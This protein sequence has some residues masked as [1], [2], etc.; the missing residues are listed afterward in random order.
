MKPNHFFEQ[1]YGQNFYLFIDWPEKKFIKY[2]EKNFGINES[3]DNLYDG[4][5]ML[6][7]NEEDR[8]EIIVVWTNAKLRATRRI[9]VIAHECLHAIGLMYAHVGV[10]YDPE[11][12]EPFTYMQGVLIEECLK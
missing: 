12:D 1:C 2:M 4:K 8:V 5:T 6:F 7:T 3:I 11:N 9:I 10:K